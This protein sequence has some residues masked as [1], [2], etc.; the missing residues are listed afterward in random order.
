L[1]AAEEQQGYEPQ[2]VQQQG[3]Q[4]QQQQPQ[5]PAAEKQPNDGDDDMEVDKQQQQQQQGGSSSEQAEEGQEEEERGKTVA[6]RRGKG[7]AGRGPSVGSDVAAAAAAAAAAATA[8]A[9]GSSGGV[10]CGCCL[11]EMALQEVAGECGTTLIVVP[12]NILVQ[13]SRKKELRAVCSHTPIG[14]CEDDPPPHVEGMP[15]QG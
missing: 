3:C 11:R 4:P 10:L 12:S 9:A 1:K 13:V 6:Q 8:A 14:V 5:N 2:Q 7:R 15:A